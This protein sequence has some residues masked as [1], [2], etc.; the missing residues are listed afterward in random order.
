MV[1]SFAGRLDLSRSRYVFSVLTYGGS[2]GESALAQLDGI[3]RQKSGRGL[4]AGWIVKMP[5][6]YIL[7]Y[8]P[9][10]GKK[11][12]TILATETRRERNP[13]RHTSRDMPEQLGE[14]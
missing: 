6:N 3:L 7:M 5:G 11:R 2:G 9:P 8:E 14:P 4:S 13:A 1:A 10:T 12:E